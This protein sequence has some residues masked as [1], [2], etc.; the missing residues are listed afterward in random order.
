MSLSLKCLCGY[1]ATCKTSGRFFALRTK[2]LDPTESVN[3]NNCFRKLCAYKREIRKL[4][5]TE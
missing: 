5:E 4:Y 2:F 3:K 1:E